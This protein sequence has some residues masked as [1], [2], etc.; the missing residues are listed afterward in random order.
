MNIS[1][2]K[3]AVKE[4]GFDVSD[5]QLE[6]FEV[7][8]RVLKE[9]NKKVNLTAIVEREEVFL[10]HFYDSLT[11]LPYIEAAG[12]SL[13]DVGSGAGFPSLPLKIM[14]SDLHVTIVDSL[15]KRITF[16][17]HLVEELGLEG[18]S[19]YHDR[20]ETFGQN[21]KFRGQFDYVTAR[22]VASL[23]VLAELCMPL[24]KMGGSFIAMKGDGGPDELLEA[25]KIIAT[26]GGKV[27]EDVALELPEDAGERHLLII[28]KKKETPNKYPRR[29]GMP[30]KKPVVS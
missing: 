4:L 27:R 15:N 30:E 21:A 13:C 6:Q 19:L 8:A 23:P 10:K 14:M 22:A 28:D 16:L 5:R 20:A 9:Y 18:V 3:Q 25:K 26:L 1:E 11:V 2:F 17:K 24:N 29:P 12:A 7:Y